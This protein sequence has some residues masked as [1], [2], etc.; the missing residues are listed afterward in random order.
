LEKSAEVIAK[1]WRNAHENL[2][3]LA[4]LYSPTKGATNDPGN[5]NRGWPAGVRRYMGQ[6]GAAGAPGPIATYNTPAGFGPAAGS[7]A[8]A[9]P[10]R[11]A[12]SD[13]GQVSDSGFF[14]VGGYNFMGSD[15]ARAMGMGDVGHGSS[16][17]QQRFATGIPGGQGPA[18]I[19]ANKYAGPDIA[20]FL[21]DLHA[22]GAPLGDFAGAYVNKPRQHGYGNAIDIET[23][24][25]SGPDNSS[26]LYRWSQANPEKFADIQARHHMRN[27]D[28]S[29]GASI[30]DWGHFEWTPERRATAAEMEAR[31][32][33]AP[34]Q[35]VASDLESI[36]SI[37]DRVYG[38]GRNK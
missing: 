38:P 22:A 31:A 2:D 37:L 9:I 36:D 11:I 18:S 1:N 33:P 23:G 16:E 35:R 34:S 14:G 32:R 26:A 15:R 28:T 19:T 24:F 17:A 10:V 7:E 8:A 25:G 5:L 6:L 13:S 3:E 21:H 30:S 27:L 20:G 4:E 12:Q 29:S